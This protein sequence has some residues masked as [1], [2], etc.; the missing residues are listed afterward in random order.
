MKIIKNILN[1]IIALFFGLS[2]L[3]YLRIQIL[4]TLKGG[5][6]LSK[7]YYNFFDIFFN[8]INL[9][10]ESSDYCIYD[11]GANDGWFARVMLRFVPEAEI[12]SFEPLKSQLASLVQ[13]K[14]KNKNFSFY[15]FALGSEN[16][17][18]DI[19]EFG[20]NGL[21]S[22]LNFTENSYDYNIRNFDTTIVASYSVECFRLDSLDYLTSGKENKVKILKIDTQG[23]EMNVIQG[24]SRLF[25]NKFF[26]F[27]IIEVLTI[28]KYT[29]GP[30]YF[31]IINK[32]T[33]Y[34][35]NLCELFPSCREKNGWVTEFD[36]IFSKQQFSDNYKNFMSKK[37]SY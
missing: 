33:D 3:K 23:F 8:K 13:L 2:D 12:I 34:G 19:N 20:T 14:D 7:G 16:V 15:P 5:Q 22:I 32:M 4:N 31:D 30:L 26:D 29:G 37:N 6:S 17:K 24:A 28:E 9:G 10:V 25:E 21:S 11:V 27:V 18:V 35:Y 36:V 1:K